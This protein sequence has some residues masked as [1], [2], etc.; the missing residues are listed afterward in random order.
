MRDGGGKGLGADRRDEVTGGECMCDDVRKERSE[1]QDTMP[2]FI[3]RDR[4]IP[5][6]LF[7]RR[8]C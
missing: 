7:T 3:I 8:A 4:A 5:G 2:C 1:L 6:L